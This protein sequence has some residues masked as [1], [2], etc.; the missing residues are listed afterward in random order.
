MPKLIVQDGEKK[1]AFRLS[2]GRL[3]IGSAATNKLVLE[4][5]GAA[6]QHAVLVV[7][8]DGVAI[9]ALAPLEIDGRKVSGNGLA[10]SIGSTLRLGGAVLSVAADAADAPAAG[11]AAVPAAAV[12]AGRAGAAKPAA[13]GAKAAA[14]AAK[15]GA[16]K[17]AAE[18]APEIERKSRRAAA[19]ETKPKWLMPTIVGLG[20]V[21]LG[22][23]ISL[24][25]GGNE[26]GLINQGL[27]SLSSGDL[28]HAR[29]LL[30]QVDPNDLKPKLLESYNDLKT[31]LDNAEN[32][33]AVGP[34]RGKALKWLEQHLTGYREK[35]L[36][37]EALAKA[38]PYTPEAK[39]RLWLARFD[40]FARRY[41]DYASADWAK[42]AAWATAI[43]ETM[44]ARQEY[45][46]VA[47]TS[48]AP[49]DADI[50]WALFYY[51]DPGAKQN[52]R[53]D[54]ARD[55]LDRYA[56]GGGSAALL[57]THRATLEERAVNY[58]N[59]QM[60]LANKFFA[61]AQKN[62]GEINDDYLKS[63]AFLIEVAMVVE[64]PEKTQL[65]LDM[66]SRFPNLDR[67]MLSYVSGSEKDDS[68]AEKVTF[69][70]TAGAS[71]ALAI[72]KA[73]KELEDR[74]AEAAARAAAE[75]NK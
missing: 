39:K 65:A 18:P 8:D 71:F 41:P 29:S 57:Q 13:A 43:G 21:I 30:D 4:S 46:A 34:I 68:A 66:L 60:E 70:S 64:V 61:N 31:K 62:G 32:E 55:E 16:K 35:Y 49:T 24:M 2:K 74:A 59:A 6:E 54:L 20:L 36:S 12:P 19:K 26:E 48:R 40:D 42:N 28:Q 38:S 11:A 50:E 9:D 69:L 52:R 22:F 51:T 56:S 7:K 37:A 33:A 14:P 47:D 25:K 45:M 1:R 53:F 75:A 15:A 10:V 27:A 72:D 73:R 5:S 23:A 17:K 44:A 67:I 3:T 63:A 58:A